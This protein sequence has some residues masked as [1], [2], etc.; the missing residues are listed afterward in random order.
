M[1]LGEWESVISAIRIMG[2]KGSEEWSD[3]T[4]VDGTPVYVIQGNQRKELT[5][6]AQ[7]WKEGRMVEVELIFQEAGRK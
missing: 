1:T 2:C 3:E 6:T 7:N 4:E 5:R